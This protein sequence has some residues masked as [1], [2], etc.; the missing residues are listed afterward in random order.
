MIM[1]S[2]MYF[3]LFVCMQIYLSSTKYG[4]TSKAISSLISLIAHSSPDSPSLILPF[5]K[6]SFG[7]TC[8]E[9][10]TYTFSRISLKSSSRIKAP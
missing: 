6:S 10:F 8:S 2:L 1:K 9:G 5:G 3:P 4:V 7:I